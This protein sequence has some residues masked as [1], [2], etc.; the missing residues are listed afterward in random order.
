MRSATAI[1]V[2]MWSAATGADER[3]LDYQ[4][5]VLIRNDGSMQVTETIT[6]RAEGQQIRRG[7][8]RDY[9]VRFRHRNGDAAEVRYEPRSVLR[10]GRVEDFHIEERGDSV[11]TYFG[12]A[13]RMLDPGVYTYTYRYDAGRMLGFFDNHDELYWNVTGNDWSFPIDRVAATVRFDFAMA[14]ELLSLE[15]YTGAFGARGTDY[16]ATT[17]AEGGAKFETT[18]PLRTGENLSIVVTWPK[19]LVTAPSGAEKLMWR[20]ADNT[21]VIAALIGLAILLGYYIPVWKRFGKDP[22]PGVIMTRYE[23]PP[24]FSPASLR[25]I[26][27]MMYDN[28]G[29]T[30]AIINLGV[31]GYLKIEVDDDEHTLVR[32]SPGRDA[33]SLSAGESELHDALFFGG[34]RLTLTD[35]HYERVRHARDAHRN[36]LRFDYQKR[37]FV[38][39]GMMNLPPLLI[40]LAAAFVALSLGTGF[41]VFV[42][43][44]IM[45][46]VFVTFAILMK[47]PTGLGRKLLD[48]VE[49]FREYLE[50]AEKDEL[51]LR[52]PPEKTPELFERYLPYAIAL[53]VEQDWAKRFATVIGNVNEAGQTGWQPAWYAGSFNSNSLRS[54]TSGLSSG[55]GSAIGASVNP[56]GSSSGSGGGGFS[57]GGGG[58]GGGGG[59]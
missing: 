10:D 59:W 4:S 25:Y 54:A 32:Q 40:M 33:P 21:N 2:L 49:G 31:K 44:A 8:F 42:V 9:P 48:E 3:I 51:E 12:N 50:I 47:R 5:D 53:G 28:D 56:P 18:R 43:L 39:N 34:D 46:I 1:L 6:V 37:Y 11:R 19:G 24:G 52:H 36:S 17:T 14:A 7:I 45:V 20:V 38:T 15:A 26:E 30:A 55:L 16:T 29:M 13:E 58:G 27:K 23:P 57:G 35:E 41:S 22:D